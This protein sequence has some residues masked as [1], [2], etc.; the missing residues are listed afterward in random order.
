MSKGLL[1]PDKILFSNL[2]PSEKLICSIVDV[3]KN[4]ENQAISLVIDINIDTVNGIIENLTEKG[5]ILISDKNRTINYENIA[6]NGMSNFISFGKEKKKSK[7]KAVVEIASN[8]E[9]FLSVLKSGKVSATFVCEAI[10]RK[11]AAWYKDI[12][13]SNTGSFD[14]YLRVI[15]WWIKNIPLSVVQEIK[16]DYPLSN[17][18]ECANSFYIWTKYKKKRRSEINRVF[19]VFLQRDGQT[20]K[21]RGTKVKS[22]I[23]VTVDTSELDKRRKAMGL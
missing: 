20:A 23:D 5:I 8:K 22:T 14:N 18:K 12:Q 17:F 1:I 2:T 16:R 19:G 9:E 15:H 21:I 4:I 11:I 7:K 6:D 13:L 3:S 10:D